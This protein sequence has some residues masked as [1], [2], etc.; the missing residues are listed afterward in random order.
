MVAIILMCASALIIFLMGA[1]HLI[2]TFRGRKFWPHDESLQVVMSQMSPRISAQT[3]MWRAW[4]GFNAS[5]SLG[6]IFFGLV[7]G[8]LALVRSDLLFASWFLLS[9]G[10]AMLTG[11]LLLARL[12]WFHV[13]FKGVALSLALYVASIFIR[14]S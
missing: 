6:A 3:S 14:N 11:L 5:H 10:G 9:L 7:Y 12:Y 13:P 1:A 4:I 2:L 8:H